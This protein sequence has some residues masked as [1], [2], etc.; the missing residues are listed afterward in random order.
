VIRRRVTLVFAV[1]LFLAISDGAASAQQFRIDAWTADDGLPQN[2]VNRVLQTRDGFLWLA[3][4]AGLARYDG[5]RFEV[6]NTG[7]TPSLQASRFANLF[8]DRDGNLWAA[9]E[10]QGLVR[11][12]DGRFFSYFGPES[13]MTDNG[14]FSFMTD[15]SG[16]MILDSQRGAV[17]WNGERLEPYKGPA[18]SDGSVTGRLIFQPP[19][20]ALW[21]LADSVLQKHENGVVTR[22]VPVPFPDVRWLYEDAGGTVWIEIAEGPTGVRSLLRWEKGAFRRFTA[23]DGIPTFRTM[24]AFDARDGSV[25]FGLR[26]GGG[27][28]RYQDGVFTRFTTADGL[29]SNNVGQILEDREGTLWVA[30]EGGLAR[31][32]PRIVTSHTA[33]TGLSADNVYP[34]FQDRDGSLLIGGWL[35]LTRHAGGAFQSVGEHYGVADKNVMAI[36]RDRDDA[37]WLGMWG[38]GGVRRVDRTGAIEVFASKEPAG[39]VVRVITQDASGTIWLGGN[40]GLTWFRDGKFRRVT[41]ADGFHAGTVLNITVSR[42]GSIW[43]GSDRG[44][45]EYRDGV[46]TN[47][48]ANVGMSGTNVRAIYEDRD[49]VLWFGTYD[50]GLFR[51]EGGRFRRFGTREGLFDNGVFHI[52]EDARGNLW[53]SSNAGIYRVARH[54]LNA[55]AKGQARTVTSVSYGRRDGMMT[56][57]CN[58]GGQPSGVRDR[59]GRLWF[60]TQKGVA[61]IDADHLPVNTVPPPVAITNVRVDQQPVAL[62]SSLRILPDQS[63]FEVEYAGLTF[64]RPELTRFRYRLEGLDEDWIDVG[65]RRAAYFSHVPPG[66]YRFVVIAA[67]RDG[68]WNE[69]GAALPIVVVPPLYR[70]VWFQ[71]LIAVLVVAIAYAGHRRRIAAIKQEQALHDAYSRRLIDAQEQDRKRIAAEI[72]DS[73]SQN[74]VL[75]GNWARQAKGSTGDDATRD[76]LGDISTTASTALRE[77]QEIAYNLGPYQL[78]RLGFKRTIETLLTRAASASGIAFTPDLADVNGM[79]AK[80]VEVSVFRMIQESVNNVI[81]HSGA[82]EATVRVARDGGG[83]TVVVQDNGRGFATAPAAPGGAGRGFGLVGLAERARILGGTFAIDAAPGFGTRIDISLPLPAQLG[84]DGAADTTGSR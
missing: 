22:R 48:G 38:W 13:G 7:T 20:G 2:P 47:Y 14:A 17:A 19:S 29:P 9:T 26:A 33:A 70:T 62:G 68:T 16:R 76:A 56:A 35:G 27:L 73:L 15:A 66:S 1:L 77:V 52:L 44:I 81:K 42:S 49:G 50:N 58:G 30:T 78:D 11:Y 25:W 72:H 64:Q 32:T 67:N 18:P 65:Q 34:V 60:P 61:V 10:G 69:T 54:E 40:S 79:V 3:T 55:V 53:M 41:G 75:I 21:Y 4:Y 74:L 24:M 84:P 51:Y 8:E 36:F 23:A 5:A 28:L 6:F 46:F 31:L 59:D 45:S 12:R 37:L 39:D 63:A 82:T 80:D 83:L 43:I 71:S 57:E